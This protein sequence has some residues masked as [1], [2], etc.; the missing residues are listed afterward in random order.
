MSSSSSLG[1]SPETTTYGRFALWL[2]PMLVAAVVFTYLGRD[3]MLAGSAAA[4]KA[5]A[6]EA[7]AKARAEQAAAARAAADDES[8]IAHLDTT[9]K[10]PSKRGGG[11]KKTSKGGA[12]RK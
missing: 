8:W 4:R 1:R 7:A 12:K 9:A 5:S 3:H 6:Q 10:G 2:F 11:S